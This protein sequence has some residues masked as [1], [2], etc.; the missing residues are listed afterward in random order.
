[1]P[2]D[3]TFNSNTK[4][5]A[6]GI[7]SGGLP[8]RQLQFHGFVR[9]PD[10]TLTTF[11]A[12]GSDKHIRDG[13]QRLRRRYRGRLA[14]NI[15]SGFLRVPVNNERFRPGTHDVS[16]EDGLHIDGGFYL[17]GDP[18]VRLWPFVAGNPSQHWPFGE[19]RGGFTMLNLGTGQ[20]ASDRYGKLFESDRK[21]VWSITA[22]PGDTASRTIE[23]G[24]P[25]RPGVQRG[26]VTLTGGGS[27]WRMSLPK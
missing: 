23:P 26:A 5:N 25:D 2:G 16:D 15:A 22:V 17:Y 14:G 1:M 9:T 21:D 24:G 6:V 12:P 11:D 10:G 4:I 19:A 13:H 8:G 27:V 20:Y 3:G 7:V 18:T